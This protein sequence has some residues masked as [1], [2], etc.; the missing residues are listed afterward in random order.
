MVET[1]GGLR[2][3]AWMS[4]AKM[5]TPFLPYE[6]TQSKE[7]VIGWEM[8]TAEG[9]QWRGAKTSD[10]DAHLSTKRPDE[11]GAYLF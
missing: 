6:L 1:L 8:G 4:N 7:Q 5:G 9:L 11:Q 2:E 3:G 10:T